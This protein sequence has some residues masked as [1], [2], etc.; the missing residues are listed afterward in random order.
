MELYLR[1]IDMPPWYVQGQLYS[2]VSWKV[3]GWEGRF[4]YLAG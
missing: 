1:S 2:C 3:M 4:I